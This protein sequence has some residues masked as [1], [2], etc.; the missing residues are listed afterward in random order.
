MVS[1]SDDDNASFFPVSEIL[2][3][4]DLRHFVSAP[5]WKTQVYHQLLPPKRFLVQTVLPKGLSKLT[6]VFIL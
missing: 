6:F 4:G 5:F 1:T 3:S 2:D